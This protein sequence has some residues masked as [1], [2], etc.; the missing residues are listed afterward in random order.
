M[1]DKGHANRRTAQKIVLDH[2]KQKTYR[3]QA[4]STSEVIGTTLLSFLLSQVCT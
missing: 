3:F 2:R 4:G 1:A